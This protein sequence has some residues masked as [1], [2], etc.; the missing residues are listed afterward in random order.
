MNFNLIGAGRLGKNIATALSTDQNMT[1]N[2]VCNQTV[3]SAQQAVKAIGCGSVVA[4]LSAL[5]ETDCIWIT[6]NDDAIASVVD[7]LGK[8]VN[9]KSGCYVVH[10][11]GV[12]DSSVL[13]PLEEKGCLVASIH[14]LKAFKSGELACNAFKEVECVIE[15][16]K[17]VCSWLHNTFT[18]LGAN[19][20]N[21]Q[22]G[23][24]SLYHAAACMASNYLVTLAHYSEQLF[25]ASGL[26]SN[27]AKKVTLKL[28][29]GN[30][31]NMQQA[32]SID[33][34]LTG[35]LMRGDVDT[36]ARHLHAIEK[37]TIRDLYQTAGLATLELVDL[38]EN[39]KK[40][41]RDLLMS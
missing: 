41:I 13:A 17:L 32:F 4:E 40:R 33:E 37:G 22:A 31:Q 10:C 36:L 1:L 34:A 19:I 18:N 7:A 2:S 15:G 35:P 16:D 11:S 25:V 24:K 12:L 3:S 27:A 6:C 23:N 14:P 28:M 5:P 21:M 20:I 8:N 29:Q 9:L 38:P 30:L 26:S 39:K